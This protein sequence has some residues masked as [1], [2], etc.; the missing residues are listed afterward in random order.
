MVLNMFESGIKVVPYAIIY[1]V[2]YAS[3]Q[4]IY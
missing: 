4:A 1:N 2:N 3:G